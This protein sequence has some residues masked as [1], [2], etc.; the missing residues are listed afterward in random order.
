[1]FPILFVTTSGY[2]RE[3]LWCFALTLSIFT[4]VTRQGMDWEKEHN[5]V[6]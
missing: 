4:S 6:I 3:S 1:M 2:K 5:A